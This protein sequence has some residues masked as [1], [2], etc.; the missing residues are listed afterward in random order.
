MQVIDACCLATSIQRVPLGAGESRE[1]IVSLG[2]MISFPAPSPVNAP[3]AA[4]STHHGGCSVGSGRASDQA[5]LVAPLALIALR[6]RR[7]RP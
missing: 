6:R 4:P 1:W 3:P 7:A 2:D 5:W